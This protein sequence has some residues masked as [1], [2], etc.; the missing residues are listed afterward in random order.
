M[1]RLLPL[2]RGLEAA[3]RGGAE[4]VMALDDDLF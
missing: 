1:R 4:V 3:I 2:G